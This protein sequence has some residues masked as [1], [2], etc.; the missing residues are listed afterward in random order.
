[1]P[2]EP[3]ARRGG[4]EWRVAPWYIHWLIGDVAAPKVADRQDQTR[5]TVAVAEPDLAR[6]RRSAAVPSL[7]MCPEPA[8]TQP[9]TF[10]QRARHRDVAPWSMSPA[11]PC[12]PHEFQSEERTTWSS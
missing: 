8:P 6:I 7:E 5:G 11:P 9:D 4:Y 3:S 10:I 2:V 12:R 1:L